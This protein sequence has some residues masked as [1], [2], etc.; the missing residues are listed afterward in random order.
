MRACTQ[1][2]ETVGA[3]GIGEHRKAIVARDLDVGQRP[4]GGA[5]LDHAGDGPCRG[6]PG[7]NRDGD[8]EQDE[9]G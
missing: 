7:R 9:S 8:L 3:Q 2:G 1:A 6:R 5:V 4:S